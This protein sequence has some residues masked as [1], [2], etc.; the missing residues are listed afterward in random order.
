MP[1]IV[2]PT[3]ANPPAPVVTTS[4]DGVVTARLDSAHAGVLLTAD[5]SELTPTPYQV[6][7][8][9]DGVSVRSGD[10]A[11]SPGGYATAYDHESPLGGTSSWTAVPLYRDGSEGAQS[12]AVALALPDLSCGLDVWLKCI[13]DPGLSMLLALRGEPTFGEESRL[14]LAAIPGARFPAGSWDVRTPSPRDLT[15]RV[16]G[17]EQRDKFLALIDQGPVLVQCKQLY[18]VDDFY[19]MPGNL[20]ESY[21]IGARDPRRNMALQLHPIR[22]PATIDA[23]LFIPGRSYDETHKIAGTYTIR[24]A[25]WPAYDDVVAVS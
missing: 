3:I 13:A 17:R 16:T 10:P 20:Q 4:P 22:R 24:T 7:F 1:I 23:P 2:D 21:L 18:G 14:N 6:R 8:L 25:T 9:R 11:F 12:Q 19:A 5:F 15:F